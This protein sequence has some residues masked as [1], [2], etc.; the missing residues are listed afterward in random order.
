MSCQEGNEGRQGYNDEEWQT[1]DPGFVPG[2]WDQDV[3]NW[4]ELTHLQI[5][6]SL[7][8]RELLLILLCFNFLLG[9]IAHSVTFELAL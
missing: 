6:S 5:K 1:S 4:E 2:M 9:L 3:Q 7:I 8:I